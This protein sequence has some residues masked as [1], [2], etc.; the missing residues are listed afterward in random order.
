VTFFVGIFLLLPTI[1]VL[2]SGVGAI[3]WSEWTHLRDHLLPRYLQTTVGLLISVITLAIVFGSTS[4]WLLATTEFRGSRQLSWMLVLPFCMPS[5]VA[6]YAYVDFFQLTGPFWAWLNRDWPKVA[7]L[8]PRFNVRSFPMAAL[9]MAAC[10][11]PYIYVSCF[12]LLRRQSTNL[13]DA[14][15]ALGLGP[16][17]LFVRIA[18]PLLRPAI[19]AGALLVGLEVLND[20]GT[21]DHFA[22]DTMATGLYR[23]WFGYGDRAMASQF[24]VMFLI[25]V[26]AAILAERWLRG[27]ARY[28]TSRGTQ[29]NPRRQQL[30]GWRAVGA[31]LLC[32]LPLIIGFVM[33]VSLILYYL[34]QVTVM[35]ELIR[36]VPFVVRS[37]SLG[38]VVSV[39]C[40]VIALVLVF[41]SD[42]SE[43]GAFSKFYSSV[44]S[45]GYAIPGGLI[46]VGILLALPIGL[47]MVTLLVYGQVIRFA[48]LPTQMVHAGRAAINPSLAMAARTLGAGD[49]RVF[50]RVHLPLVASSAMGASLLVLVDSIKELP[51]SMIL[52]PFDF[53]LLP[54]R[55][56]NLA[57]DERLE[58]ASVGALIMVAISI[59]PV[60]WIHRSLIG[61]SNQ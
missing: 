24:A 35:E 16:L 21:V 25:L 33:P 55:I 9:I 28:W 17:H 46:A 2:A 8:L 6:A 54:I 32:C 3:D 7:E 59:P 27:R 42:N 41:H 43:T 19:A 26:F 4:A 45:M 34:T 14:G 40:L 15:R 60:L 44:A 36:I 18:L 39:L 31:F 22:L 50:W 51:V 48:G 5:Y 30:H 52:R 12:T 38:V 11:S 61:R 49:M 1:A 56:H 23:V 47:G 20:F 10:L 58:S 37:L 57:S 29:E 13:F 53:E